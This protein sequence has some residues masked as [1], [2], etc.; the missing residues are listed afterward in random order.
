MEFFEQNLDCDELG[1]PLTGKALS[2]AYR[3]YLNLK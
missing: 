3:K 1:E 2:D